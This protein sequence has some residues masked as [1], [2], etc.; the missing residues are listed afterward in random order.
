VTKYKVLL[1]TPSLNCGGGE[2]LSTLNIARE[3]KKCGHEPVYMSSGGPL[4]R[5][6]RQHSIRF[7]KYPIA[8]R[9][10]FGIVRGAFAIRKYLI[11]EDVDVIHAQTPW[12]ALM[13]SLAQAFLPSRTPVIWHNR[14]IKK[15][16]YKLVARLANMFFDL[17]ISNSNDEESMLLQAGLSK[18]KSKMIHNGLMLEDYKLARKKTLKIKEELKIP[19]NVVLAGMIGRL[20]PEKGPKWLVEAANILRGENIHFIFTGDGPQRKELEAL[21]SGYGLTDR[22]H[23]LGFRDDVANILEQLDIIVIPSESES[24]GNVALEAMLMEVPV[25]A[26]NVGGLKEIIQHNKNGVLVSPKDP[27]GIAEAILRL[28]SDRGLMSE[29]ASG[30]KQKVISYF[31]IERVVNEI[32]DVYRK[33][34]IGS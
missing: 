31:N 16:N 29:L 3:L 7:V 18:T 22:V 8:G 11:N 25:I 15:S 24:F 14:G 9:G 27:A 4:E 32:E 23:L 2:E 28:M 6:L 33:I 30:G 17:V 20:H 12:P 10:P 13:A 1:I 34:T 19:D 21:I 26:A 5:N